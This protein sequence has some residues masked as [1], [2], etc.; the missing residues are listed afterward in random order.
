MQTGITASYPSYVP[1]DYTLGD[2]FSE[3]GK[4][5]MVFNGPNGAAFNLIEEK[6]SWDTSALVRNYIEP[7]WGNDYTT[8]SEQGITIYISNVSSDAAWV[9]SGILYRITSSGTPLTKKQVRSI[10]VSL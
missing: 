6:S 2:I 8:T 1:R 7:T 4:I 10:V 3:D 9:N 5:T